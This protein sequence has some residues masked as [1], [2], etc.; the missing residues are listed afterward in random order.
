MRE[1]DRTGLIQPDRTRA[2]R[3]FV[4]RRAVVLCLLSGV[5]GVMLL[6]ER[7][8]RVT[9]ERP[10][11]TGLAELIAPPSFVGPVGSP[12]EG[13]TGVSP[14][15]AAQDVRATSHQ[16]KILSTKRSKDGLWREKEKFGRKEA[17]VRTEAGPK[18][19]RTISLNETAQRKLLSHAPMEET[20]KA[21]S[22]PQVIMTLPMPDGTFTQF[23]I[24]E[25]PVMA[26][27]LAARFP[28][29][30]TYRGRGL[31]DPTAT[32]RLDVTP[33]GFHAIVL[34]SA[35]TVIVEPAPELS[36]GQYISY[37]QRD[38]PQKADAFSCLVL[39]AEQA[40][41]LSK[42]LSRKGRANPLASGATL[43]TY[44]LALAATAEFTQT[45]GGG[46]VSGSLSVMTTLINAVNSI[47]ER[48]LAIHLNLVANETSI[49]FTNSA[50]DGYTSDI[51]N[52]MLDQNQGILDQRIGAAN[53][54]LGMVLD[55]HV[56]NF[57]PGKFIFQGAAQYQGTC[58]NG[59]KGKGVTIFRST[60]P[61]SIT[62]IYVTAHELGHLLG[63]LHSFNGTLD[64]CG[65][66][67]FAVNAYEPGSGSTIMGYRGGVLPNGT[68]Y[69]LCSTEELFSNDTYFHIASIDQIT[70]YTTFGSVCGVVTNTGNNPPNV[71]A[72][73]DYSI[74]ANTPF[75]L[76]ASGSDADPDALTYCWEEFDLGAAGPPHTDN[77]D[78]PIFRSFAPVANP[79][80]TFP[81]WSDILSGVPTFGE[82]LPTT[83]R[84]MTFR[85]TVRD[86]HVGG[87]GV[88][89]G[90]MHVNVV[91]SSGPFI[92]TQPGSG[93]SWPAGSTQTVSW[94]VANTSSAP[95]NCAEVRVLLSIDGGGSFPFTLAS[96]I[97][98]SG[99]ASI[100]VPNMPTSSARIK[101][102]AAGNIFFN[103]S[104]SN[105]TITPNITSPPI[106]LT[107]VN[108]NRSIALDSV[109]FTR[110]PFALTTLLNFSSDQRTRIILFATGLEL[111]PGESIS[112]VTA[113]AE[114]SAH[115][116]YPLTV[117]Y[118]GKVPTFDWLTQLNVRLPDG[119]AGAGDVLV[120]ISVRGAV[121][122]KVIIGV[123]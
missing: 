54:D 79:A 112:V 23:D 71:D 59:Q 57:Q 15:I 17:S 49:I 90:A 98:N 27:Q 118:V 51:A 68:Y 55:G 48:D 44:R 62:G 116:I 88:N 77:G 101:V 35:G 103:V 45:F 114:D 22:Q 80:R 78:R 89:T 106:L 42:Q 99:A 120:S 12:R 16:A 34:S 1:V 66:S 61:T 9:A 105:F 108:T 93:T 76:T 7:D 65:P 74:P 50:T 87:G 56:Y 5:A 43:R 64:D 53:Y 36:R 107:D 81:Q 26:P 122:N 10:R 21:A 58:R 100:S 96:G 84:T 18:F 91:S 25:S 72:G 121:S 102:E 24:E 104:P 32:T 60:D 28:E 47:Y 70:D 37:D 83:D 13:G 95:I 30:K 75:T 73:A 119:I 31:D 33:D 109:T 19:Y 115:R 117:E 38:A 52:T 6:T 69:P 29:I 8:L 82:S 20:T 111:M 11:Q 39:G 92:V 41:V 110:D 113:Q 86:N 46:T 14:I 4:R 94:N 3:H 67:R 40:Q 2:R 97:P 123:R 85:V 63:A